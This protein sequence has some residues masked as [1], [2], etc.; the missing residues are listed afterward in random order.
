MR[1][2]WVRVLGPCWPWPT[3]QARRRELAFWIVVGLFTGWL[4]GYVVLG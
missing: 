3:C 2:E 4:L 1:E